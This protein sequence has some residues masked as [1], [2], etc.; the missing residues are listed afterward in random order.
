MIVLLQNEAPVR[1][2]MHTLRELPTMAKSD[3]AKHAG[4]AAWLAAE[5]LNVSNG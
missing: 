2:A 4:V 5:L 1:P 3:G